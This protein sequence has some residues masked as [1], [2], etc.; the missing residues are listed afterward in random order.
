MN[1]LLTLGAAIVVT[2]T[3]CVA[4]ALSYLS[5]G[6]SSFNNDPYVQV[7][8]VSSSTGWIVGSQLLQTTDGGK[9]WKVVHEGDNGTVISDTVVYDLHRFQF[10]NPEVGVNWRGNVFRR[11]SD[12]GRSWGES[13]SAPTEKDSQWL[14]FFFLSPREGWAVGKNVYYTNNSGESWQRLAP[15]PTGDYWHQRR[16]GIDPE[17]ANYKPLLRFTTSKNGIMAKLDGMVQ[18]TADGGETWQ[19]VFEANTRLRDLFFSDNS[20]G[21]LVGDRGF[22]AHTRDG[23]RTWESLKPNTTNDLMAVHFVN[24]NA[25]CAVG[26]KSTIVCTKDGGVTW[27]SPKVKSFSDSELLVSISFADELNGWAVGGWGVESSWGLLPSSSNI[28]LT[29]KDGGMSWEPVKLP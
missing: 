20:N 28:A 26:V 12:G 14:S 23:G 2:I 9:S 1:T 6:P 21:W 10:I 18:L 8:F 24:S 3:L 27:T 15:I 29:T 17:L 7:Q 5:C 4:L 25:G 22:V 16:L 11:T 13:F 19:L